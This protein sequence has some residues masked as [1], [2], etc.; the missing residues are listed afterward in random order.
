MFTKLYARIG[1]LLTYRKTHLH[2]RIALLKVD[3]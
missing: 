3:V 1:I 2:D